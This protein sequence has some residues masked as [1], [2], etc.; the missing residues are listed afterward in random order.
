MAVTII[1]LITLFLI[2]RADADGRAGKIEQVVVCGAN[3][4]RTF[5][6]DV[7]RALAT[8][9]VNSTTIQISPSCTIPK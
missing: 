9:H 4:Q 8:H 2:Q 7:K 5:Q 6:E 3:S 1:V